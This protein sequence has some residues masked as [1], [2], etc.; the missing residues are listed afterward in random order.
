VS[1]NRGFPSLVALDRSA[2]APFLKTIRMRAFAST[3]PPRTVCRFQNVSKRVSL[4]L[5]DVIAALL[6]SNEIPDFG[7]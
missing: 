1:P 4:Y 6:D 7:R 2:R 5:L 3:L